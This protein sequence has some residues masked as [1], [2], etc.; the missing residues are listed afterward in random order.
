[1]L[2]SF[3]AYSNECSGHE[4]KSSDEPG[5]PESYAMTASMMVSTISGRLR[6]WYKS[7][8]MFCNM[9][10]LG[11]QTRMQERKV[12]DDSGTARVFLGMS[13][14]STMSHKFIRR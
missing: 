14:S 13:R 10:D 5:I 3:S 2:G 4:A 9:T 8:A 11:H 7:Q 6:T 12:R 1:M